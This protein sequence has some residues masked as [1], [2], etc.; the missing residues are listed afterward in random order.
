MSKTTPYQRIASGRGIADRLAAPGEPAGLAGV[1][2]D[3]PIF[4]RVERVLGALVMGG[5]DPLVIVG[6]DER[7]EV[8]DRRLL[9]HVDAPDPA[10][11]G[12][13]EHPLAFGNIFERADPAGRLGDPKPLL[14]RPERRLGRPFGPVALDFRL[15]HG[16]TPF[17]APAN[18]AGR[19]RANTGAGA[20][21]IVSQRTWSFRRRPG[22]SL[23]VMPEL[24]PASMRFAASLGERGSGLDRTDSRLVLASRRDRGTGSC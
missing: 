1:G 4:D 7:H 20:S 3:Y 18:A 5:V 11:F 8:A 21:S 6:M 19:R 22:P 24:D 14:A 12:G 9:D 17:L 23:A 15:R 13:D 16:P 2:T 10:E